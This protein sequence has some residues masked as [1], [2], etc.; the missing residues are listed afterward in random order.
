MRKRDFIAERTLL[1]LL[2]LYY[3]IMY[4]I[5]LLPTIKEITE[6]NMTFVNQISL[7]GWFFLCIISEAV[8]RQGISLWD[9]NDNEEE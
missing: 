6:L 4:K 9:N 8:I 3:W 7:V 5:G 1:F 2:P